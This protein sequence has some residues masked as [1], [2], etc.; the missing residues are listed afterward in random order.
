MP[1]C[2][3]DGLFPGEH[4]KKQLWVTDLPGEGF[5]FIKGELQEA[6]LQFLEPGEFLFDDGPDGRESVARIPDGQAIVCVHIDLV[7]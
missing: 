6:R 1:G 4:R 5:S 2:D 3:P 7:E